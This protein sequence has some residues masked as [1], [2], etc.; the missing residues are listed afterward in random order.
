MRLRIR[1]QHCLHDGKQR[2]IILTRVADQ[3][4][5]LRRRS[6]QRRFEDRPGTGKLAGAGGVRR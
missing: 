3:L 1:V 5:S 6:L 4:L 2:G